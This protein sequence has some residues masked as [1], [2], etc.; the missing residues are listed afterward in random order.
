MTPPDT[1]PI[2][3][4][5]IFSRQYTSKWTDAIAHTRALLGNDQI[6]MSHAL[7]FSEADGVT[8]DTQTKVA[9]A[10][11]TTAK[12]MGYRMS[13]TWDREAQTLYARCI[14]ERSDKA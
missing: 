12:D 4:V 8:E 11:R 5:P 9:Q 2:T 6:R 3:D 14:G 7:R 1:V 13:V 10:I